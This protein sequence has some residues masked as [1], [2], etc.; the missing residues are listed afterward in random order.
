MKGLHETS[1]IDFTF[2]P[3]SY[4]IGTYF[5]GVASPTTNG[6]DTKDFEEALIALIMGVATATGTVLVS[7]FHSETNT[8]ASATAVLDAAGSP[9]TFTIK[10]LAQDQNIYVG[11][12]KAS[13]LKKYLFVKA[14]VATDAVV[15]AVTTELGASQYEPI[16]Q[17]NAVEFVG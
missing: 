11:R 1:K 4:A 13:N 7:M 16:S 8:S 10:A 17:A 6:I 5:N 2:E 15:F 9:M 12:L 14:V 3:K